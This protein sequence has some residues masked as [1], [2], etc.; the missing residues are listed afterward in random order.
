MLSLSGFPLPFRFLS[1]ASL[2]VPATQP[3]LLPFRSSPPRLTAAFRV[4][5]LRLSASWLFLFRSARFPVLPFRFS[6]SA[7]CLFPFVLPGFAPTAAT[8]VLPSCFRLRAF[9]SLPLSFVR[10]CS[11]QTTQ[12]SALS[13]PFF[14]LSPVGGS[15]G[16][17]SSSV[18]PV[19]MPSFRFRY[20]ACCNSFLHSPARFTAATP[21][22]SLLPFGFPAAPPGFRF[23]FWLLSFGYPP[24]RMHPVRFELVVRDR[25]CVYYHTSSRLSTTFFKFFQFFPFFILCAVACS[26]HHFFLEVFAC[27][28]QRR[29]LPV[30]SIRFSE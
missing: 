19:S 22:P 13:F 7:S 8:P 20:S 26:R 27:P 10:F 3:L 2:P 6:Y 14:P 29:L 25:T 28:Y 30:S 11:A 1:S 17:F 18:R 15:R 24:F 16:A 4:L 9:P 12:P 21:T 23:R 5:P